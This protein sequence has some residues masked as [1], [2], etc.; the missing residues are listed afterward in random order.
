MQRHKVLH[1]AWDT[2]M[3]LTLIVCGD[4]FPIAGTQ[5]SQLCITFA[6]WG[7]LA[8]NLSHQFIIGVAYCDDKDATRVRNRFY[9]SIGKTGYRQKSEIISK[10]IGTTG[11]SEN[12]FKPIN[13]NGSKF[14]G[15]FSA[16]HFVRFLHQTEAL[17]AIS[18]GRW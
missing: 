4:A 2:S 3:P 18:D 5:W 10:T 13:R 1:S 15:F 7:Q 12:R 14:F 8:R 17:V 9:Q 16:V 11:Y 6:D